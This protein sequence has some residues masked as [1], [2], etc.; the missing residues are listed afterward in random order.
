MKKLFIFAL[1][2]TFISADEMNLNDFSTSLDYA[3]VKNVVATQQSDGSWCF[4]T[5]VRHKD[6]GWDH[7]ANSWQV[8]DLQGNKIAERILAHPH[9]NEQ[10]FTRSLCNIQIPKNLSSV[11]VSAKCNQHGF[12]GQAIKVNLSQSKGK[13]FTVN[14]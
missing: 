8:T 1:F 12:A 5:Q 11:V 10:P 3:Q 6:E 9:D 4:D 14:K 7:Y 13:G 2:S